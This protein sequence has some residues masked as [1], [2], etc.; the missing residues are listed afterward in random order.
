MLSCWELEAA[1]R[2][3][4]TALKTTMNNFMRDDHSS[5]I[6]FPDP[7]A[8][9]NSSNFTSEGYHTAS[10]FSEVNIGYDAL[11]PVDEVVPEEEPYTFERG[12]FLTVGNRI[13]RHA[14][15][16]GLEGRD[17]GVESEWSEDGGSRIRRTH[18][19]PYVRTPRRDSKLSTRKNFEWMIDAP[20]I[21]IQPI[22]EI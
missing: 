12:E 4:F 13:R 15:E 5:I 9:Y 2:P 11:A 1:D 10:P 3:T 6:H 18:S 21:R 8:V 17:S 14:S 19:N 16:P 22:C 7:E 20:Q